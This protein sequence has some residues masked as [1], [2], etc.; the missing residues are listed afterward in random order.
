VLELLDARSNVIA[1]YP[2]ETASATPDRL[3]AAPALEVSGFHLTVPY[4]DGVSALR[5]R[6]GSV[7]L[8]SQKAGAITSTLNA[9]QV[10]SGQL[11]W[12]GVADA[13]YLV[14]A[15]LDNG[16]TWEVVGL[17]LDQPALNLAAT[18]YSGQSAQF[19]IVASRGLNSQTLKLGPVLVPKQ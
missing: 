16:R 14:R 17:D 13:R 9:A 12:S 5:V 7:I 11:I 19:E 18:R 15:S 4:V 6:R 3:D 1:A 10:R 8:G 2:F